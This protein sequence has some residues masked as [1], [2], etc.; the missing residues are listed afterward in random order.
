MS[1]WND[2]SVKLPSEGESV[3]IRLPNGESRR[4]VGF[5]G[6][7]FWKY[8]RGAGGHAYD[9]AAWRGIEEPKMSKEPPR[10]S[11]FDGDSKSTD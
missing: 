6:G 10:R 8:R 9:V 3:E 7:R 11:G 5:A 4:P 2:P 1:E